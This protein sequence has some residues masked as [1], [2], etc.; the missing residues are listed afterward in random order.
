MT[1]KIKSS[2][3][4]Q[5]FAALIIGIIVGIAFQANP[6]AADKFIKPFGTLFLN[7]IKMVIVPLV[8]V[9]IVSGVCSMGDMKLL[10]K[11]GV[12]MLA[13]YIVTT[14][15]AV[16]IGLL[17][18]RLMGIGGYTLSTMEASFEAAEAPSFVDTLLNIIPTNPAKA[19]ADGNMLQIIAFAIFIGGGIM[20]AGDAGEPLKDVCDSMSSVMQVIMGGI[21]KFAPIGVFA[22]ITSVIASNGLSV[23]LPLIK[24][25]A[26]VYIGCILHMVIVYSTSIKI[27]SDIK[28]STFFKHMSEAMIF[29]YTTASSA[30]T[31]PFTLKAT[32]EMGI[33]G[34]IRSF[35]IPLG[36]TVNMDGTAVFQGICAIFVAG[37]YGVDLTLAQQ[38]TI[39]LSVTLASVG[40]AGVPGAGTVMLGMVLQSVGLPLDGVAIIMGVERILD[41]ARTCVNITGDA[42][43]CLVVHGK[44]KAPRQP[45]AA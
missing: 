25:I 37:L 43:C 3:A 30:A 44:N 31:I 27:F 29:A 24:L 42:S 17:V 2:L 21:M 5:I 14:S 10:G 8:F 13:Y 11:I 7:L 45:K 36:A 19:I 28:P 9:S 15:I 32:E 41:M 35:V 23:L 12:K 1:K 40:T 18:A 39:V 33:P 20:A 22:L 6:A 26:A 34:P 16:I 4:I 38:L